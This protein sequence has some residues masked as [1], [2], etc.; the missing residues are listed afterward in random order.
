M[1]FLTKLDAAKIL[2]VPET[3]KYIESTPDTLIRFLNGECLIVRESL[4][5]IADL[6]GTLR[7]RS[8]ATTTVSTELGAN[9]WT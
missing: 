8:L 3:I 4:E 5:E 9:S 7:R 6:M 1:I 2:V